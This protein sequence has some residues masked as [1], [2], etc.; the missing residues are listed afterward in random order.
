MK[1]LAI[2]ASR[3]ASSSGG[4]PTVA[5]QGSLL[6]LSTAALLSNEQLQSAVEPAIIASYCCSPRA[7]LLFTCSGNPQQHFHFSG[8]AHDYRCVSTAS[9]NRIWSNR[10]SKLKKVSCSLP[11]SQPSFHYNGQ[12]N[13]ASHLTASSAGTESWGSSSFS[14]EWLII[15]TK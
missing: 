6:K 4:A 15:H 10:P 2:T 8:G 12:T 14:S 9:K 1:T 5:P 7:S 3:A 13:V 11:T